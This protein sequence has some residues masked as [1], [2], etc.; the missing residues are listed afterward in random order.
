MKNA[1]KKLSALLLV[2][3]LVLGMIPAIYAAT[4][5]MEKDGLV[6]ELTTDKDSYTAG[7]TI[8]TSVK[9]SNKGTEEL[10][11]IKVQVTAPENV[12]LESD[13]II[14]IVSLK[15]GEEKE[16]EVTAST[17]KAAPA[18]STS[19]EA[20]SASSEAANQTANP[21]KTADPWVWAIFT[22]VFAAGGADFCFSA[23]RRKSSARYLGRS[24]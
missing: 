9:T 8:K 12:K 21:P 10:S 23:I 14:E 2:F 16:Q 6:V 20:S 19:S 13:S 17:T 15:A 4:G 3:V 5:R 1:T 7:E 18:A 11:N 24:C 22:I